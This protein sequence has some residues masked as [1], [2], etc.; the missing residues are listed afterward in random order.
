MITG[1]RARTR[2]RGELE[3]I[4]YLR[5]RFPVKRGDVLAG[6][7]DDA[8]VLRDGYV[9]S[10]DSFVEGTHFDLRYFSFAALGHHCMAASLS[11]LAAM[12]A[13]PVSALIALFLS[14]GINMKAIRE[15]YD[16]FGA[17]AGKYRCG[18]AGGDIVQGRTFGMTITVIGRAKKPMMRSAARPGELLYLTNFLGLA[19][20]GRMVLKLDLPRKEFPD[21][22]QKHLYPEPRIHEALQIA[23]CGG[24]CIDTSDGLSTDTGHLAVESGVKIR[25]EAEHMPIHPEVGRFC[26]Q[27]GMTPLDFILGAGEDFEL[28]FTTARLP[29]VS[30]SRVFR[31]GMVLKGKGLYISERGRERPL[32]ATGFEHAVTS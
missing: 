10:I 17:L 21:S 29:R 28:L 31:I 18:I 15:L 16:G 3:I 26:A 12:G 8:M 2:T 1:G 23:R 27:Q 13:S 25:I 6:I 14:P 11:D 5:K 32:R 7:G 20:V 30:G 24:A 4:R 9:V 19:E 22:V